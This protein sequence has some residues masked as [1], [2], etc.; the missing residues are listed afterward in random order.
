MEYLNF[1]R[2][3]GSHRSFN[4]LCNLPLMTSI[5][6]AMPVPPRQVNYNADMHAKKYPFPIFNGHS[7]YDMHRFSHKLMSSTSE[8][9]GGLL[10]QLTLTFL[11]NEVYALLIQICSLNLCVRRTSSSLTPRLSLGI[12]MTGRFERSAAC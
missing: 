7:A 11:S 3:T 5:P 6:R 2:I 9:S 12:Q 4:P 8:K 10:V 1:Q